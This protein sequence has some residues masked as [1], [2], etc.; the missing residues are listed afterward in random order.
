MYLQFHNAKK[1]VGLW[2]KVK[3]SHLLFQV[4][5]RPSDYVLFEKRHVS[6]NV[7]PQTQLDISKNRKSHKFKAFFCYSED[8]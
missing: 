6:T 7:K 4:T 5:I 2:V 1:L 3:R 8:I